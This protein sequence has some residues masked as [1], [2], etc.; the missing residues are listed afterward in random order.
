MAT[1]PP[2]PRTTILA[3]E[4]L[5]FV[6]THHSS[7]LACADTQFRRAKVQRLA[8]WCVEEVVVLPFVVVIIIITYKLIVVFCFINILHGVLL[9]H[10]IFLVEL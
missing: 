2:P 6:D 3:F 4:P 10:V 8:W 1:P 9:V 5:P 7:L